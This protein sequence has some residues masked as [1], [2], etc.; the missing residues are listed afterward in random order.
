MCPVPCFERYH[1]L[2]GYLFDSL[3]RDGPK[4]LKDNNGRPLVDMVVHCRGD[5]D[6]IE[7]K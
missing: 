4:R 6:D 5:L 2:P 7:L 1:T 3:S